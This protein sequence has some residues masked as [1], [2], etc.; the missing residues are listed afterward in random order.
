VEKS[1]V[2]PLQLVE[3]TVEVPFA[4]AGSGNNF[5]HFSKPKVRLKHSCISFSM[6]FLMLGGEIYEVFPYF[7]YTSINQLLG[8]DGFVNFYMKYILCNIFQINKR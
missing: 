3:L 8:M 1:G 2:S 4:P 5:L 7:L 6:R